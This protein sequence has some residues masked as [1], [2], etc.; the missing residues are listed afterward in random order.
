MAN[1]APYEATPERQGSKDD[2]KGRYLK[3]YDMR[4]FPEEVAT[5]A[6][7]NTKNEVSLVSLYC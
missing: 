4:S 1:M 7:R 6:S 3:S 5:A 2:R